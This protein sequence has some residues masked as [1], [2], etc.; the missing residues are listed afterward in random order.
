MEFTD[1]IANIIAKFSKD[2]EEN[3]QQDPYA[4]MVAKI[5]QI[6]EVDEESA[7]KIAEE[8]IEGIEAYKKVRDENLTVEQLTDGK[9]KEED[10]KVDELAEDIENKLLNNEEED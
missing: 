3:G 6:A 8:I 5:M 1:E 9:I 10:L 4:W 2:F 7:K